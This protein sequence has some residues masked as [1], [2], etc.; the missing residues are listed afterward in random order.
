MGCKLYLSSVFLS[1]LHS[2]L[3]FVVRGQCLE[4]R[5]FH[6]KPRL[7]VSFEKKSDIWWDVGESCLMT[8]TGL[9]P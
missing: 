4:I 7:S 6:M 5:K 1:S 2:F 9:G 3:L 8:V